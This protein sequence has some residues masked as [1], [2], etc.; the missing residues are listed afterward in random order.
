M[1][2]R[3]GR[4][5][6]C[7]RFGCFPVGAFQ[8]FLKCCRINLLKPCGSSIW[9]GLV[10]TGGVPASSPLRPIP[11]SPRLS[12]MDCLRPLRRRLSIPHAVIRPCCFPLLSPPV[13]YDRRGGDCGASRCLLQ[14]AVGR[15][16]RAVSSRHGYHASVAAACPMR[17]SD[18]SPPCRPPYRRRSPV[19]FPHGSVAHPF[20]SC[21][22]F[23]VA[24]PYRHGRRGAGRG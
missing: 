12:R 24:P 3:R 6:P 18:R 11:I 5:V 17:A 13:R 9:F 20:L 7:G 15:V 2:R 14:L 21:S 22:H 23:N 1:R 19:P 16:G 10:N 4:A 8:S